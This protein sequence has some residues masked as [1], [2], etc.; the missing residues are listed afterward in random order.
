MPEVKITCPNC[1]SDKHCFEE[2]AMDF[3]S[4]MCFNCGFTSNSAY[5][6]DSDALKKMQETSS[7]LMK[8]ISMYDY[9]RK[10]HWFPTILNMGKF[11]VLFPEGTKSNWNWKLAEVRKLSPEEQKNPMYEGHEHTLDIENATTFGQHEF[12][13]AC[14]KMGIVKDIS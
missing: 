7:E 9:D 3:K 6:N 5:S 11:G 2:T 10:I 12:L 4:Y 1:F 13:E 8:E 14:K